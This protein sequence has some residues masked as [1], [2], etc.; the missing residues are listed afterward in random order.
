MKTDLTS[1]LSTLLTDGNLKTTL[2]T[3]SKVGDKTD[4]GNGTGS[5]SSSYSL[6]TSM[7]VLGDSLNQVMNATKLDFTALMQVVQEGLALP[8]AVAEDTV[9]SDSSNISNNSIMTSLLSLSSLSAALAAAQSQ[10]V[11]PVQMFIDK[12]IQM[13]QSVIDGRALL[14]HLEPSYYVALERACGL[15]AGAEGEDTA[16]SG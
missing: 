5:S 15:L 12:E 2:D 9:T 16:E 3:L 8:A 14:H 4:V 11:Q 1:T 6:L 13:L 7:S 10:A